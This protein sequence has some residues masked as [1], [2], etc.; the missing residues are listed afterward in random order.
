MDVMRERIDLC[1]AP[2]KYQAKSANVSSL[3]KGLNSLVTNRS[4]SD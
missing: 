4:V 3:V 2:N 1:A